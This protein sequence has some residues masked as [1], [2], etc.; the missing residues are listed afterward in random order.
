MLAA[1]H[2]DTRIAPQVNQARLQS[3]VMVETRFFRSWYETCLSHAVEV[4]KIS[5]RK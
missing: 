1:A 5:R 2:F 3:L 4:A